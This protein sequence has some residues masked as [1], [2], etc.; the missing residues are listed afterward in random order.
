MGVARCV[1]LIAGQRSGH[2]KGT[3]R[4]ELHKHAKATLGSGNVAQAVKLPAGEDAR[5][6]MAVH[7]VDF[8]NA[9]NIIVGGLSGTACTDLT[10]PSM[11][12]GKDFEFLWSDPR[13]KDK[14]EKV[15]ANQYALKLFAW[16]Q[17]LL[18]SPAV[19]PPRKDQPWPKNFEEIV[20]KIFQRMFRVYA[21][22]YI[23]HFDK[24]VALGAEATVN[25]S[26]KHLIYF[27]R[28]FKLLDEKRDC[29]PLKDL[30]ARICK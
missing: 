9:Q 14:P 16:I 4:Y 22:L 13:T 18:D 28:E 1:A 15:S 20:S 10:C 8:F 2:T 7:V 12:A 19:F 3:K 6:W 17:S 29:E 23:S 30:L 5:E 27:S 21:H 24:I 11:T 25:S 26:L